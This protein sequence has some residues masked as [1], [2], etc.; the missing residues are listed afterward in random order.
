[1][2]HTIELPIGGKRFKVT[3]SSE[4]QEELY[5]TAA[6]NVNKLLN[7]YTDK[8]PRKGLDEILSIVALNECAKRLA[9]ESNMGKIEEEIKRVVELSDS[10]L[11]DIA[12]QPPASSR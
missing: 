4:E 8:F 10:Y 5:R 2:E 12:N 1:M 7:H 9:Y 6:L 11:E 3:I